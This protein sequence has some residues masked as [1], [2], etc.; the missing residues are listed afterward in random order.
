MT[1]PDP[2][3]RKIAVMNRFWIRFVA[4]KL[5]LFIDLGVTGD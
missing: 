4:G 3:Y 2:D 1:H 5:S